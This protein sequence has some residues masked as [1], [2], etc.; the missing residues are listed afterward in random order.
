MFGLNSVTTISIYGM[1]ENLD[2]YL[3]KL[4]GHKLFKE[5]QQ[6][7]INKI[8]LRDARNRQQKSIQVLNAYLLE[9]NLRF[10]IINKQ[11]R[12]KGENFNKRYWIISQIN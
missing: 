2:M 4:V 6:E 7:L 11:E 1:E 3:K 5:D 10:Q 8:N 9:N 12:I